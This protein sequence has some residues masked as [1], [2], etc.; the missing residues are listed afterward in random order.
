MRVRILLAILMSA[1]AA[2]VAAREP[3]EAFTAPS[4]YV[5]PTISPAG[6]YVAAISTHSDKDYVLITPVADDGPKSIAI[7]F[8]ELTPE[9]LFWV[10]EDWLVVRA[11]A[12]L[13]RDG[14]GFS[15]TRLFAISRATMAVTQLTREATA[16][17]GGEVVWT[18]KDGSAHILM[19]DWAIGLN[20]YGPSVDEVDLATGAHKTI[21][22]ARKGIRRYL[23]DVSGVVRLG[24]GAG[25]GYARLIYRDRADEPFATVDKIDLK[26]DENDDLTVPHVLLPEPGLSLVLS[27]HE[28]FRSVYRYDLRRQKFGERL[29]AAP[30]YDVRSITSIVGGDGAAGYRWVADRRQTQWIDPTFAHVQ[31]DLDRATGIGNAH[32]TSWTR[33]LKAFVVHVA[34]PDQ[35]GAYYL[36]ETGEGRLKLLSPS[37]TMLGA[38]RVGSSRM[39]RYMAR[40]GLQI[41]AVL[42][43]PLDRPAHGLPLVVLPHGGPAVQDS[44]GWDSTANF[45]AD[46]GYAVVR[47]NYRGSSGFGAAFADKGLNQFG[48]A[49]QDDLIDAIENLADGG[50]I[51]RKRVCIVGRGFG[52]FMAITAAV[53]DKGV[54]RCAVSL[55][56]ISDLGDQLW[57]V[58]NAGK[59]ERTDAKG[60]VGAPIRHAADFT[61][62]LLLVHGGLPAPVP[63]DQSRSLAEAL[64]K[65]GKAY[66]FVELPQADAW[67]SRE[68][69]RFRYFQELEAFLHQYN[70]A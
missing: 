32:I 59:Q 50:I 48:R 3:I 6:G 70:P 54:Y 15:V 33:D 7:P 9:D 46:R 43:V 62:P 39:V 31:A 19:T 25:G 36:F 27:R 38:K 12:M 1:A 21:V 53:R 66:R 35:A 41:S 45:L 57:T 69:D 68:T 34:D 51:D 56:G 17:N 30:G 37:N 58:R 24:I 8:T 4:A 2:R 16:R 5:S 64:K 44:L 28:G 11:R 22:P 18:A 65:A 47:P 40:D 10:N 55:N 20:G 61:T 49:M 52:G 14:Q 26:D 60:D 67:L 13:S 63:V 29:F 23:A 42:T